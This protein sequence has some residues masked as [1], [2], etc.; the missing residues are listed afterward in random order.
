MH[1]IKQDGKIGPFALYLTG[2]D[3]TLHHRGPSDVTGVEVEDASPGYSSRGRCLQVRY[4]E[5]QP[6]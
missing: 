2:V 4:L 1:L 6:H 5:D 3:P